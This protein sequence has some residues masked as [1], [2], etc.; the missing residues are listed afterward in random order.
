[1]IQKS[2]FFSITYVRQGS[3][4]WKKVFLFVKVFNW[5]GPKNKNSPLRWLINKIRIWSNFIL[6]FHAFKLPIFHSFSFWFSFSLLLWC[7]YWTNINKQHSIYLT[8]DAK[9][10]HAEKYIQFLLHLQWVHRIL[11]EANIYSSSR[12]NA[13][14]K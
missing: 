9:W 2:S 5:T 3:K 13:E 6:N 14:L 7:L 11:I 1:M 10:E 12:M 4:T 8:A